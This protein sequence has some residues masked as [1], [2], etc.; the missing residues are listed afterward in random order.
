MRDS[1]D[2]YREVMMF[3]LLWLKSSRGDIGGGVWGSVC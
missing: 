3:W 1:D 2:T